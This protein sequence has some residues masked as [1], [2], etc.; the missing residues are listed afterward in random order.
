VCGGIAQ[1]GSWNPDTPRV[2][3]LPAALAGGAPRGGRPVRDSFPN[4]LATRTGRLEGVSR[5]L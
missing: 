1:W 5:S 4:E 3:G 2:P